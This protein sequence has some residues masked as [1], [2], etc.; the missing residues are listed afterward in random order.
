VGIDRLGRGFAIALLGIALFPG[1]AH[2]SANY[3]GVNVLIFWGAAIEFDRLTRSLLGF[4]VPLGYRCL[5]KKLEIVPKEAE[6]VRTIFTR[7]V[8]LGSLGPLIAEL[9]RQ[10]DRGPSQWGQERRDP[11]RRRIALSI[12]SRTGSTSARSFI[13]VRC[14]ASMSRPSAA[15][16]SRL[17]RRNAPPTPLPGR[18]DS[19]ARP[20]F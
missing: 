1:I 20:P 7:Y 3:S 6:A 8:K 10:Q 17:C 4:A 9:D 12:C 13:G 16:C 19:G 15:S 18:S 14:I 5:D 11:F 2:A